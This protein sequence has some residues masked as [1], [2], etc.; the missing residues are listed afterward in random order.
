[1]AFRLRS[2]QVSFPPGA[3]PGR[4]QRLPQKLPRE[5]QRPSHSPGSLC[6]PRCPQAG[7]SPRKV[8]R[9][10]PGPWHRAWGA[11]P[12]LPPPPPSLM[13]APG[14]G[15]SP[16]RRTRIRAAWAGAGG[17]AGGSAGASPRGCRRGGAG[18][19]GRRRAP[20]GSPGPPSRTLRPPRGARPARS[21]RDARGA[22]TRQVGQARAEVSGKLQLRLGAARRAHGDGGGGRLPGREQRGK[23]APGPGTCP[24]P[25]TPLP[26]APRGS[27]GT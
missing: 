23:G 14:R 9:F 8:L 26:A 27:A 11:P 1:M 7:V 22:G 4:G 16:K 21:P 12:A 5:A 10:P 15:A 6:C 25:P 20:G 2:K 19:P 13:P 3:E 24:H 18:G 17:R